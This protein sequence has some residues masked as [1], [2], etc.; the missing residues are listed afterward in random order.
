MIFGT[1]VRPLLRCVFG[2]QMYLIVI[3]S[4][5]ECRCF[6]IHSL[7]NFDFDYDSI[8]IFNEFKLGIFPIIEQMKSHFAFRFTIAKN[9]HVFSTSHIWSHTMH[10]N[11]MR[12]EIRTIF[13]RWNEL[14]DCRTIKFD[15]ERL[16]SIARMTVSRRRR[17]LLSELLVV[18]RIVT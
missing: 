1:H 10:S 14:N 17:R 13:T 18:L 5:C 3:F 6:W 11:R 16:G 8:L 9:Y 7:E 12:L 4:H 15:D 2:K